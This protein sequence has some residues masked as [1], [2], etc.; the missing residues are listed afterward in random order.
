[1]LEMTI[2]E[3]R[4]AGEQDVG[5]SPWHRV[6]QAQIDLFAEAT[7][8]HLW[9]HT[10]PER[11]K[12]GPFGTTVAHGYCTLSLLPM[13][14]KQI[15]TITDAGTRINYGIDKLRFT[16]PVP[17]GS[18]I[19]VAARLVN[20]ESRGNSVVYK[21]AVSVEVRGGDRPAMIG[22]VLYLVA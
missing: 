21:L 4:D 16:G 3:L 1:M 19:R 9:I 5:A 15:L 17:S 18:E 10:D 7:G 8:D 6:E 12:D 11:A 2:A 14:L 20:A 22:E 13:L